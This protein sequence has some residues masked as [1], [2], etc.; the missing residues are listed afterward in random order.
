MA[1]QTATDFAS[2]L[3]SVTH[4]TASGKP[5]KPAF[6]ARASHPTTFEPG[7]PWHATVPPAAEPPCPACRSLSYH[8]ATVC[9][10]DAAVAAR[11]AH[12]AA[13]AAVAATATSEHSTAIADAAAVLGSSSAHLQPVRSR[14]L[15]F[16]HERCRAGRGRLLRQKVRVRRQ[17]YVPDFAVKRLPKRLLHVQDSVL[18]LSAFASL[19]AAVHPSAIATADLPTWPCLRRQKE[20]CEVPEEAKEGQVQQEEDQEEVQVDVWLLHSGLRTD[21]SACCTES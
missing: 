4:C 21:Q 12:D 17:N 1:K 7:R 18:S 16:V 8:S 6:S 3:A 14:P 13:A 11:P 20:A 2:G 19:H 9:P 15:Q 5:A 10:S